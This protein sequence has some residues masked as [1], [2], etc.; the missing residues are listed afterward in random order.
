[1][2]L[3]KWSERQRVCKAI[4]LGQSPHLVRRNVRYQVDLVREANIVPPLQNVTRV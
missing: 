2:G 3:E 4:S 1:M